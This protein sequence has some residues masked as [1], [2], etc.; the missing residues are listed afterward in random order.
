MIKSHDLNLDHTLLSGQVFRWTKKND[1]WTG[2]I[3]KTLVR[4]SYDHDVL[5]VRGGERGIENRIR[6]Y[7][8]IDDSYESIMRSINTDRLMSTILRNLRGLRLIRQ[9]PWECTISYICATNSNIPSIVNMIE[10]LS[11]RFGEQLESE[12]ETFHSFPSPAR[13]AAADVHALTECKVGYRA[14]FIKATATSILKDETIFSRV[15]NES[16]Q[17]GMDILVGKA[18]GK[19]TL[20]GIGPKVADCILLFSLE[21]MQAFPIDTWMLRTIVNSYSVVIGEEYVLSLG[22]KSQF[23]SSLPPRDY[24]RIS[25]K[26]R[27]YFGRFAGYA[28]EFLYY[29]SRKEGKLIPIQKKSPL[30]G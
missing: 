7:F 28:Q 16:Y 9:D 23:G 5:E 22:A 24:A 20:A 3:E 19:K 26:M 6:R 10:N 17:G 4:L 11:R 15:L 29:H 25:M 2:V 8:R 12:G 18:L 13:I 27:Q 14:P 21:K 1:V 30:S